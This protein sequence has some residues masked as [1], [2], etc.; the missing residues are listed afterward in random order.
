VDLSK[1]KI[2]FENPNDLFYRRYI[3]GEGFVAY[4][5]LKELKAGVNPLSPMNRLIFAAGPLTG[6]KIPGSARNSV[7]AKSPLT[8]G[9]GEAEVGG[10]WGA[11]LKRVGY[12]AIIIQGRAKSP[13]YLWVHDNE[14]EIQD[15]NH[16]WEK[17]TG[18]TKQLICEELGDKRIQLSHIGPAGE[19]LVRYACVM[20][21]LNDAAGRSGMGAVMGSKNLKAVAVR[22]RK[23]VKVADAE[24][25]KELTKQMTDKLR[26]GKWLGT[27]TG[28]FEGFVSSGNLPIHNFRDGK[29]ENAVALDPETF[30][31]TI[32]VGREGCYA[33]PL[34][35]KKIVKVDVPWHVDPIYGGPE[36]EALAAFGSNCG[37]DDV[38]AV[39]KAN[40]LCN[41]Y[42][43][44]VISTG[45]TIGFAME[46]YEDGIL[47]D[48]DTDGLELTF[49]NSEAMV[50]MV[51]MIG[52]REGLGDI[53]AEG[54]KWAA[55]KLGKNAE[56]FAVHV[57]G[58]EVPMHDPR[59]KRA[60]GLGYSISPTGAEHM[61]NLHDDILVNERL[62]QN[63]LSPLGILEPISMDDLG[64][65]KVRTLIYHSH[66]RVLDNCLHLCHFIPWGYK[67]V[68]QLVQAVTSWNTTT[69]EL[70]KV[71]ERVTTLARIFNIREKFTKEDDWLPER[72]FQP[73]MSGPLAEGAVD[74][75][76]LERARST[77]YEMMGWNEEGIPR[78]GKLEEL[79]IGWAVKQL[80]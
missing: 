45:V 22:G 46:C 64:P 54:V 34:R 72:F 73:Q 63:L 18:N 19:R 1:D 48:K 27:G 2:S 26:G 41:R 61:T 6:T 59:L 4:F 79:D 78:K 7:G 51:K 58:Q 70:M 53:L 55:K 30:H 9:F 5:L 71:G 62:V 36:Y 33:C 75:N 17:E 43:L 20:N 40:E 50:E 23:R 14:V 31:K 39:S 47:T 38:N 57:K 15:A 68:V 49:G 42:S 8:G 28:L 77:Y 13:V 12:D 11:E 52:K 67:A 66:W 76:Q 37:I 16:L 69:W 10:Y 74:P 32:R 60:L 80:D 65:Q 56:R 35:C 21:G 3:G 44:D 25:V 24:K 29:F